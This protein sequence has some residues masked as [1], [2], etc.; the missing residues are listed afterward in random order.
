MLI[1][2]FHVKNQPTVKKAQLS[3]KCT[4]ECK[5]KNKRTR[6]KWHTY[7]ITIIKCK[8]KEKA[9]AV[10]YKDTRLQFVLLTKIY[11]RVKPTLIDRRD[12]DKQKR[13]TSTPKPP[14]DTYSTEHMRAT[15]L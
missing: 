13:K 7:I 15:C 3:L 12:C 14:L 10:E 2:D 4:R 11:L 9:H 8:I 6:Q 5:K 1:A